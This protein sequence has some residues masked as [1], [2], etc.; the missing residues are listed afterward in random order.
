MEQ[1]EKLKDIWKNQEESSIKFTKDDI[2]NMVHKKSS[3][4]VKWILIISILEFVLPNIFILFT[5]FN[6]TKE[7]YQNYGLSNIMI[8]YTTIHIVI[9]I[10]FI[11]F[12]YK[13]YKNISADSSVKSLL[14]DILKTRST[15]KYYIY[16]NL[17]M[18]AIIGLHVFYIVFNS[19]QFM[20][21]LPENANII[22]IWFIAVIIFTVVL[23]GFWCFYRIIYGFLLRKLKN[24]YTNLQ[25]NK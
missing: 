3:S 11:Y 15:V 24:N 13:N 8:F 12:F 18:A 25:G 9:I 4:I 2:Y 16:Y 5:D 19:D 7:V 10:G 17:I 22:T 6:S 21:K 20:N 14:H 1:L 23:F